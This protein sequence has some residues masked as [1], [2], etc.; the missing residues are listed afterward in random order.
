MKIGE[1]IR[2]YRKEREMTQEQLAGF[3]GV[4]ASA[5]NKWEKG[6]A[7]PDIALLA[8][9]AR[10][11]GVSLDTLLAYQEKLTKEEVNDILRELKER[12][13]KEPYQA[14]FSWVQDKIRTFPNS[15]ELM[16]QAAAV[17]NAYRIVSEVPDE[18]Q[19]DEQILAC[20]ERGVLGQDEELRM[21]AAQALYSFYLSRQDYGKAGECLEYFSDQNPEK[22]Y[23]QALLYG[24]TGQIEEAYRTY[25][26][27]LY[28]EQNRVMMIL[29]GIYML[30]IQEKDFARAHYIADKIEQIAGSFEM[31]RYYEVGHRLELAVQ[32][33]DQEACVRLAKEMLYTVQD[34]CSF[35]KSRL[36]SH[37][38]FRE[39]E[40]E[41]GET[42]RETLLRCFRDE[43]IFGFME[44]DERW[45]QI[46]E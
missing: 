2:K 19:Y 11:L 18:K 21:M 30:N 9:I 46:V 12:M 38:A 42:M 43:E 29:N 33:Q 15:V 25:E 36:Y 1:I 16:V 40:K 22:K 23:R 34:I 44:Q 8:P 24:R 35:T 32:E 39:E 41:Y 28:E 17:L 26:E 20:F 10:V 3:L 27:L 45:Q 7:C 31:G 6:S 13:D 5:V 37:M 4:T 14:V